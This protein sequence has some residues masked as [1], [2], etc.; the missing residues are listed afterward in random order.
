[1]AEVQP[2]TKRQKLSATSYPSLSW[3]V[4][5]HYET[6]TYKPRDH[7]SGSDAE[8]PFLSEEDARRAVTLLMIRDIEEQSNYDWT[9]IKDLPSSKAMTEHRF[10]KQN[11]PPQFL[12]NALYAFYLEESLVQK[13][14]H[15]E[16]DYKVTVNRVNCWKEFNEPVSEDRWDFDMLFE[17]L[18]RGEFVGQTRWYSLT[19]STAV[20]DMGPWEEAM[21]K[22]D[23][24]IVNEESSSKE[25]EEEEEEAAK[26][27]D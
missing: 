20:T 26:E 12:L 22:R 8:G 25:E 1:M 18:F 14:H 23:Y 4:V 19:T 10:Y 6:D 7:D 24:K 3:T 16:T 15:N 2:A 11:V 5:A 27:V 21:E 13:Q 17:L 9:Y